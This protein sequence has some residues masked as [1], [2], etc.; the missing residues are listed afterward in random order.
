[1]SRRNTNSTIHPEWFIDLKIIFQKCYL[2]HSN[3][4]NFVVDRYLVELSI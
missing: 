2:K 4:Q 1:M 3:F